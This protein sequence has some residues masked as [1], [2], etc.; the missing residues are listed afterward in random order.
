ML[1]MGG[2]GLLLI[3]LFLPRPEKHTSPRIDHGAITARLPG[4]LNVQLFFL[5]AGFM[6]VET[7]AVVTMALLFGSTWVVNSVVFLAVLMMILVAN[8][9]TLRFKPARLWPYYAGLF[10]T[11]VVNAIVPLDFFLG[12]SRS[13]QVLGSCLLVFAPIMFAAVIFAASFKRTSEPDRAFG[14]NIAGA[15][16]GGL[17]EYSSM[18]LGF[19]YL[20]LVAILFYAL[21]AIGLRKGDDI[22]GNERGQAHLPDPRD[23]PAA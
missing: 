7:K 12:M 11:L 1:V 9:W 18:L 23:S 2:L 10:A 22:E 15:L 14:V 5:G 8:L 17:A 19:Q 13:I 21:S 16:L 6:L 4:P 3:F 20:V